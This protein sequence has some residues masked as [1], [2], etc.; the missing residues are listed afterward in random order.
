MEN[1]IE[2]CFKIKVCLSVASYVVHDYEDGSFADFYVKKLDKL[3]Q[4]L[5]IAAGKDVLI[6][7]HSESLIIVR[8]FEDFQDY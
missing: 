2:T 1:L 6:L 5:K 3:Q 8:V 4:L 7:P